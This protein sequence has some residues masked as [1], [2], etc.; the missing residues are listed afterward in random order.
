MTGGNALAELERLLSDMLDRPD[1]EDEVAQAID[2]RFGREAAVLALDMSGF[3]RTT[4]Q[5]GIVAFLLMIH[6]MKQLAGSAI[7]A[8][9]GVVVKAEADNLYCLFD[10]VAQAVRAAQA[11][12][13]ALDDEN[14]ACA[15]ERCL[16]AAIGIGYGRILHLP[17]EDLFGDEVNLACK[18]GEDIAQAGQILLTAAAAEQAEA[19]GLPTTGHHVNVSGLDLPYHR[20]R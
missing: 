9:G 14:R 10:G 12:H 15:E 2:A 13:A 7:A 17:G 11:I 1:A 8:E 16:Y 5:R 3:S 6:R 18:L 4:R 20:A 19:A